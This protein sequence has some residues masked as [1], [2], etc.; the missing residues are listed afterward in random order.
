M[1]STLV[2]R[3]PVRCADHTALHVQSVAFLFGL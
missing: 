1:M 3:V 2:Y